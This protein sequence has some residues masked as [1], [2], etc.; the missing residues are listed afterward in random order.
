MHQVLTQ[1]AKWFDRLNRLLAVVACGLLV[2]ITLAICVEI[3]TR[4]FFD[5]SNLWLVELSEITLLYLTFL[6][7]AWVLG[8]DKHVTIDLLLDHMGPRTVKGLHLVLSLVAGV[9]CLI[10]CWFG[11]VTVIDQYQNDI[12][13]PTMMAPMTFWITAI[14]PF[15]LLLLGLQF[16]R[17]GVRAALGLSLAVGDGEDR[18]LAALS[19]SSP[20]KDE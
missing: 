9:T 12:R 17:R 16:F 7:A 19:T 8:N 10:V 18:P 13:E 20:E 14:V 5:I 3:V 2:L 6:A 4:S 11:V 15:G 1:A